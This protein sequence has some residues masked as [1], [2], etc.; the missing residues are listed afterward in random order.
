MAR[1]LNPDNVVDEFVD[2]ANGSLAR[3]TRLYTLIEGGANA[4]RPEKQALAADA[5]FRLGILWETFV[6]RW[7]VAAISKS[8]DVFVA[9]V[10]G[11]LGKELAK[12]EL[13]AKLEALTPGCTAVPDRPTKDQIEGL[14]DPLR[15]NV[16]FKDNETWIKHAKADLDG[17]YANKVSSI[18]S[19]REDACII[20]LIKGL[21]N[22]LAHKSPAGLTHFNAL[23]RAENNGLGLVG[24]VNKPLVRAERDARDVAVYL[25]RTVGGKRRVEHLYSRVTDVAQAMK[26]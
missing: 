11:D 13:G 24:Q 5:A 10:A 21:R 12:G 18:V 19:T 8:P 17:V 4:H 25:H 6:H 2:D 15:R 1:T 7:H 23:I 14:L 22:Y 3:F 20:A 9:R 16:T 26:V